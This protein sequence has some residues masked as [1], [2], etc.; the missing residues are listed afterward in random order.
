MKA[1]AD[2]AAD[3]TKYASW[4]GTSMATPHVTAVAALIVAANPTFT[5]AQVRN[6]LISTATKLSAMGNKN[7][8]DEYGYGLL[9]VERAVS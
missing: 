5:P 4:D 8:T 1:S 7:K 6:R 2:R 3:E 9:N